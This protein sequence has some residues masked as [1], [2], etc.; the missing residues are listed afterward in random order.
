VIA[1]GLKV[2]GGTGFEPAER[3]SP[4]AIAVLFRS[5]PALRHSIS[6]PLQ[7]TQW[8]RQFDVPLTRRIVKAAY[9]LDSSG[10]RHTTGLAL[11]PKL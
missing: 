4:A 1:L 7:H 3:S 8:S 2:V 11:L 10:L 9:W 5:L 6:I